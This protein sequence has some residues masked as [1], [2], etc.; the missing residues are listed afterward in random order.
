MMPVMH[1]KSIVNFEMC[2]KNGGTHKFEITVD[3]MPHLSVEPGTLS[4]LN[5]QDVQTQELMKQKGTWADI[6]RKLAA[7][8][9]VWIYRRNGRL[10]YEVTCIIPPPAGQT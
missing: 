5:V 7:L 4:P 10:T 2:L 6:V 1:L 3:E 8:D 9:A